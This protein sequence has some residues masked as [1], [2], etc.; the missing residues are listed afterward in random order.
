MELLAVV[1]CRWLDPDGR[2]ESLCNKNTKTE[3]CNGS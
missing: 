2:E 1:V 3:I